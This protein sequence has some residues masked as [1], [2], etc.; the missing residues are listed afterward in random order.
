[1]SQNSGVHNP[2]ARAVGKPS[3]LG[4]W[5]LVMF[6]AFVATAIAFTFR[7]I[8]RAAEAHRRHAARR[9]A[10][11]AGKNILVSLATPQPLAFGGVLLLVFFLANH[12]WP[13][14]HS[15]TTFEAAEVHHTLGTDSLRELL[16]ST[17][18]DVVLYIL[19]LPYG[20]YLLTGGPRRGGEH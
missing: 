3:Y 14:N 8:S 10:W 13:L 6:L 12:T 2:E 1:M 15:P 16:V 5:I 17:I 18:M 4:A 9:Q 11:L 20:V 7:K 19:V